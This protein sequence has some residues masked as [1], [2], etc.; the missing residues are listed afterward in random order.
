[1][2]VYSSNIIEDVEFITVTAT[3]IQGFGG[4]GINMPIYASVRNDDI[5][6]LRGASGYTTN[7]RVILEADI[8]SISAVLISQRGRRYLIVAPS[9]ADI[10]NYLIE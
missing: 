3:M 9:L 2:G 6:I 1:M 7:K 5:V 10:V 4:I 8:Y